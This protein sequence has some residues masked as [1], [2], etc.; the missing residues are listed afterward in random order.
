MLDFETNEN[1]LERHWVALRT[2]EVKQVGLGE[3]SS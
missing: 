1:H 2:K 3:D